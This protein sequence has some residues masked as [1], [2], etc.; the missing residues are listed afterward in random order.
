MTNDSKILFFD[1]ETT[2]LK[3]DFGFLLCIGWKWLGTKTVY[4]PFITHSANTFRA[5]EKKLLKE[6]LEAF[7]EADVVVSYYGKGFDVPYLQAKS[8]EYNLG[9]LPN[10]SH[11]DLYWTIKHNLA[12][13]RKSL[14]NAA[15]YL[16]LSNEKTPVEGRIWVDAMA[17]SKKAMRYI[18]SHCKSDVLILEELYLRVRGLVRTHP[19]VNGWG[20]CRSCGSKHLQSRGR[21][22][23]KCKL[24]RRRIRCMDCGQ[25]EDRPEKDIPFYIGYGR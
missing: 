12:I 7:E 8:L 20:P 14:Q 18:V 4:V 15:Y 10:P 6:F 13:S 3:A 5:E 24:P 22:V 17:G 25:W 2:N 16:G 11:V 23:T 21:Y 9:P 19:R 1:I